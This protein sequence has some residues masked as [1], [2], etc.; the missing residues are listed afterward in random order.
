[1]GEVFHQ[2]VDTQTA[3]LTQHEYTLAFIC[4]Q[5]V[6]PINWSKPYAVWE[7]KWAIYAKFIKLWKL[8]HVPLQIIENDK[9]KQII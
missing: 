3:L 2:M 4:V 7:L 1:M 5:I 6:I 8:H 9:G